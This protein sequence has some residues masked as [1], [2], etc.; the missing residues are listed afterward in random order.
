MDLFSESFLSVPDASIVQAIKTDGVFCAPAA[1]TEN[2]LNSICDDVARTG[3]GFNRNW[4]S[5]VYTRNQLF[6]SHMFA[7]S[8]SFI[9]FST[10]PRFF[11]LFDQIL[12]SSYRLKVQRY[13]ETYGGHR[14]EWHTDNRT[15]AHIPGLI[16][17]AYVSDVEDGEF[18]YIRASQHW[19]RGTDF[20][21]DRFVKQNCDKELLS[22]KGP[23]GTLIIFDIYGIHRAKP[24]KKGN[25]VRKNLLFQVDDT[26]GYSEPLLVNPEYI[27]NL[28]DRIKRYLG[29]GQPSGI[30]LYPQTDLSTMPLSKQSEIFIRGLGKKIARAS[31]ELLPEQVR[32]AVKGILR[33]TSTS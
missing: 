10:H 28:D 4:I 24:V 9:N 8:R 6:L 31:G 25:F 14:M 2:F 20:Y 7:I 15:F 11:E 26:L 29:F 32:S 3:F 19:S 13:Y 5:P 21:T 12:Q 22:F 27:D 30:S 17:L 23:K 18:Q 16:V 33:H 1:L